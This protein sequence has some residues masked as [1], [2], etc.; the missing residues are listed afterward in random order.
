MTQPSDPIAYKRFS[1]GMAAGFPDYDSGAVVTENQPYAQTPFLSAP[2]P[3][4]SA[5]A[6]AGSILPPVLLEEEW[7]GIRKIEDLPEYYARKEIPNKEAPV[8]VTGPVYELIPEIAESNFE[9]EQK[10]ATVQISETI[11]EPVKREIDKLEY[12]IIAAEERP[13]ETP[14][15]YGIDP[16]YIIPGIATVE[17]PPESSKTYDIDLNYIIPGITRP[18]PVEIPTE[19]IEI[20]VIT[21]IP[22][23]PP[24]QSFTINPISRLER[25]SYYVQ[26][27][28]LGRLELVES[29]L[30][31]IEADYKPVV[32]K[33]DGNWYRILLGPLNQGESGA[34][35]QRF[36]SIGYKGSFIRQGK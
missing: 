30:G 8:V 5:P 11:K 32:F 26:I 27:A 33:D 15:I 18:S 9:P 24:A 10:Q 17:R 23:L 35:L 13:P 20:P 2:G 4:N 19:T 31:S 3:I 16:N 14:P 34:I 6:I 12:A 21:S 28:S 1:D 29:A 22:A 36:K 7:G 25:G